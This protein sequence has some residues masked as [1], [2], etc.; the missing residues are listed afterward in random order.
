MFRVATGGYRALAA[1]PGLAAIAAGRTDGTVLFWTRPMPHPSEIAV[2]HGPVNAVTFLGPTQVVSAGEDGLIQVRGTRGEDVASWTAAEAVVGLAADPPKNL[3]VAVLESRRT[4]TFCLESWA[5]PA[6]LVLPTQEVLPET[7][8]WL[9]SLMNSLGAETFTG[10]RPMGM[11]TTPMSE[12]QLS[13][14]V[15]VRDRADNT[16]WREFYAI[17]QPLI[18]G[19]LRGLGLKEHD[20][21][22]LTQEVFCRLLVIL[23]KLE[24][25]R[26]RRRFHTY[27]W[28]LTYNTLVDRARRRKVRDQAEDE[29]VRRFRKADEAE[30]RKLKE[31]WIRRH[32]LRILEVVLPEVRATVSPTVW[33]C[34]EQ[35]LLHGR[36][37]AAVAAA[38]GIT[39][40][41]VYVHASRVLKAVRRRCAELEEELGDSSD[42]DLP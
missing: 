13:L 42:P 2:H 28:R 12:T 8:P 1:L 25:D 15:R 35:R 39:A 20:A 27:L 31:D 10:S 3:L 26:Q 6:D 7:S 38:L 36:P 40:N 33:A 34:F 5:E 23:P 24:L 22:E 16:S 11:E 29:W 18:F 32:R 17:Y 41:G 19:Y 4:L 14:L 37:A 21:D 9:R 30:T